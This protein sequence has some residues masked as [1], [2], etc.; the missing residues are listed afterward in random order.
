MK[1]L[2]KI[3]LL[4]TL[5]CSLEIS[6]FSQFYNGHQMNFGKNRVQY[7]DFEWY[8]YR[9]P[10]YDVYFYQQEK[11]I[12]Q[13]VSDKAAQ[14]IPE[15]EKFF[16]KVLKKR[17]IFIVYNRLSRFRQS[18][19]GL[20]TGDVSSNL[21]G[22]V[23]II[24]NKVFIYYEGDH[25]KLETQI[26][27]GV[28]QVIISS[29]LSGSG[30][31]NNAYISSQ[32]DLP[33]W[34][35]QGLAYYYS[36]EWDSQLEDILRDG[37]LSGKYKKISY[38]TGDDAMYAGYSMWYY[39]N[40]VYGRDA[41]PGIIYLTGITGNANNAFK[42]AVNSNFK[43]INKEWTD[44]YKDKFS[45][46]KDV[47][48]LPEGEN[49]LEK[50]KKNTVY[51][52]PLTSPDGKYTFYNSNKLGK[53]KFFIRDNSTGDVEKFFTQG[54]V[55][56]QIVDYQLPVAAW[57]KNS[58]ILSFVIEEEGAPYL[59]Q[60]KIESGEFAKRLLPKFDMVY[61]MDYSDDGL[62]LVMSVQIA[63]CTDIVVFNIASGVFFRVTQ[64]LADDR[65]PKFVDNSTKIV[66]ASNRI[67]DTLSFEKIDAHSPYQKKYD[68]FVYDYKT[69]SPVLRRITST[70]YTDEI[71]PDE[72]EHNKFTYL[73]D[74]NGI[75]NRYASVYDS[76]IIAVDTMVH[77]SYINR[78]RPVSNFGRNILSFNYLNKA[79]KAD[80]SFLK[81]SRSRLF[82]E[83]VTSYGDVPLVLEKTYFRNYI[84]RRQEKLDSLEV[85]K[86]QKAEIERRRIDS[87]VHNPPKEWKNPD[88]LK[89]DVLNYV[90]EQEKHLAY[91]YIYYGENLKD[92]IKAQKEERPK[93]RLSYTR[94]YIDYLISQVDFSSM[95]QGYQPFTTGPYYFNNNASAFFKIGIKDLFEDY[96]ISAAFRFGGLDSYEYYFTFEDLR[97]RWDKQYVF[98]R[99]TYNNDNDNYD[100]LKVRSNEGMFIC[101]YPF[102]QVSAVKGTL[103]LRYDKTQYLIT[104]YQYFDRDDDYQVFAKAKLEYVFDNTRSLGLNT[105][106]GTRFKFWSELY[107]QVEGNYDIISSWGFDFRYYQKIHRCFILATRAA[108]A[109]SFGT[110][111]ILYYLGG[112]DNWTRFSTDNSKMFDRSI[113]IDQKENYIYQAVGTNMRGFIQNCRNGNTFAVINTELRM[114][115]FRYLLN[116]P[117]NMK[118]LRDFQVI[119]FFD[120]G[121]A[122]SGFVPQSTDNAYNKY[123]LRNG[124]IT[125]VIDVERPSV[126][127]GYGFGLRT[128]LLGYFMRF[129]WA[130]GIEGHVVLPR[131]FYFSLGLDF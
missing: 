103:G 76:S 50:P 54:Q 19:I 102:N 88:S 7:Y 44:Y 3:V 125:M 110:G 43:T 22:V 27:Q 4:L 60:Y 95:N 36:R 46:N 28:A 10:K 67:S 86:K 48:D 81:D 105:P 108:G 122:W 128:S 8:Y 55:L 89:Y 31:K 61:S 38:L 62:N 2:T 124:S 56:D 104:D 111:K 93:Q 25:N 53:C 32:A 121:S 77:Y 119:G 99:Y 94:F 75:Y 114:P 26:R 92:R 79:K 100:L 120:A 37:F 11:D 30:L 34:Y 64:D 127:A 69:Q 91:Q 40:K 52:R 118:M 123:E 130:W 65:D 63:G 96:R 21:G 73:S 57:H 33:L 68:I 20:Q 5:F 47:K 80:E 6:G 109:T 51:C 24:D 42:Q 29:G 107:Q 66:F 131:V 13:F 116:H 58:K 82:T 39:I 87:I 112:V 85:V 78:L 17:L 35:S 9:Y 90:F 83:D 126:V 117:I 41:I 129:D 74:E 18:N 106:S 70:P 71:Y 72:T 14:I 113:R 12:A 15:T 59:Y 98:H 45:S 23:K 1:R 84:D 49:K 115:L 97:K 101:S 16:S